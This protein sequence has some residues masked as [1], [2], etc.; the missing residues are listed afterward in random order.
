MRCGEVTRGPAGS[1]Y[2]RTALVAAA[3]GGHT[4]MGELLLD[5]HADLGAKCRVSAVAV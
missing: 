4:D 5:L 2:G 1:Q 3:S